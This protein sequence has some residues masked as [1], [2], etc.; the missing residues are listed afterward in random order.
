[1]CAERV[2]DLPGLSRGNEVTY[3]AVP[4]TLLI[5]LC[6]QS[7]NTVLTP[8]GLIRAVPVNEIRRNEVPYCHFEVF[9]FFLD[10]EVLCWSESYVSPCLLCHMRFLPV[11]FSIVCQE[12]VA[13][14]PG[15]FLGQHIFTKVTGILRLH[16][17]SAKLSQHPWNAANKNS[18]LRSTSSKGQFPYTATVDTPPQIAVNSGTVSGVWLYF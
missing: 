10:P 6:V 16:K 12:Y 8:V 13:K 18:V 11:L 4:T 15:A 1:L 5:W 9:W 14:K 2:D 17:K 3:A 7:L